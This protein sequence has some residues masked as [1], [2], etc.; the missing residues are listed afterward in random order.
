M[1][2]NKE[3]I[4]NGITLHLIDTN[5]FKTN[6]MAIFLTTPISREYVTY[7][8]LISA[9]LRRGN[10][11]IKT[12]E[13]LSKKLEEM[14]G[15]FFDCGLD[16]TGDNHIL[17]FYLETINDEY[18]PQ[19][20][21]NMLKQAINILTDVVFNPLIENEAFKEEYLNQEKENIR[22][23]INGKIDNKALYARQRCTEE[24]YKG[25]P[26]GLY[27]FGYV[28]DLDAIDVKNLYEYYRKLIE[29]C[30]I[31]IF[32]SGN[33]KDSDV[34]KLLCEND[35][36]KNLN[37]REANYIVNGIE[38]K[39]QVEER[40]ITETMDVTQGKLVIG[41]DIIF[42]EKDLENKDILYQAMVYNGML[43][44]NASSKLFQNVREKASLAYTASSS[45]VRYKSN[46]FIV[47][48]IEF[49]NFDKALEII[50]QQLD[51]MAKGDF[52][53]EDIENTKK[54]II[55]AINSIDDEQDT[56]ITYF[57]G[58][59]ILGTNVDLSSYMERVNNV[60]REQIIEIAK[61]VRINTIYFLRNKEDENAD[62]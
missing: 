54:V 50:K 51:D 20:D 25:Q 4:K 21:D 11:N 56:E 46:I 16:K 59:E 5:K 57:L 38:V 52:T 3:N 37:E 19:N 31:D 6:L 58:Q 1:N 45:Y 8:A 7:N 9:I 39:E 42:N 13:E 12:Q 27:R 14:Y 41:T 28:E 32:V 23:H 40:N 33:V 61:R 2:Y 22:Q 15:A 48:G 49:A 29:E 26:A 55:S 53:D 24:M 36:I 34:K 47:A 44:G 17:K 30:K 62:N 43:G 35:N 18:I 60:T 10:K